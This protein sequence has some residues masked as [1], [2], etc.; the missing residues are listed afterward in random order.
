MFFFIC[1]FL[2]ISFTSYR[3]A[4]FNTLFLII[5]PVTFRAEVGTF[6]VIKR[7]VYLNEML[8]KWRHTSFSVTGEHAGGI[9][10]PVPIMMPL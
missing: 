1:S 9:T 10:P 7:Y 4:V 8:N 5:G 2:F 6:C 3:Y